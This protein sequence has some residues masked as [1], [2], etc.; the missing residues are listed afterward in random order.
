MRIAL[1]TNRYVDFMRN[2]ASIVSLV[3]KASEIHL[4]L[5]VLG[6]LRS[7][8]VNGSKSKENEKCLVRFLNSER[9]NILGPDEATTFIYA[10]LYAQLKRLGSPVPTND[11]WIASLV[12]QHDLILCTRDRHFEKFPQIPRA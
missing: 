1:D 9:V 7:G 5:I 3:K 2:D 11:L 10:Q 8:F 4:P 12:V 6:E